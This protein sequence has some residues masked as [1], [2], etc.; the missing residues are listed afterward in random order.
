M[1]EKDL[2]L[3]GISAQTSSRRQFEEET[4]RKRSF[5][6]IVG[7]IIAL[8][9]GIAF[10]AYYFLFKK[11]P[12]IEAPSIKP[13]ESIIFS[14]QKETIQL[15]SEQ[16][17]ELID[18]IRKTHETPI[19]LNT[20]L[21]T[22]FLLENSKEYTTSRRFFEILG[23]APPSNLTQ[24][25]DDNFTFG[26]YYFK[27]NNPF[28]ILKIHSLDL[29]LSG[30]LSWEKNMANSLK[31]VLPI[32]IPE[33]QNFRDKTISNRDAR[34]LYDANNNPV[35]IYALSNQQYLIISTDLDTFNEVIRRLSSPR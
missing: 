30:A 14:E 24:A 11:E 2:L 19:A 31:D 13:P 34:I 28:L 32:S 23:I 15:K 22:S 18:S 9:T 6:I 16:K 8:I 10:G 25:L 17:K 7:L 21:T 27:K 33:N 12:P 1:K 20:I 3:G 35:L 29:A 26:V 4:P 5:L